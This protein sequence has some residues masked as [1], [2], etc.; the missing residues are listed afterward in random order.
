[1]K[2][3]S[4]FRF[5][6]KQELYSI[7]KWKVS[8]CTCGKV[9]QATTEW[10]HHNRQ[11][12]CMHIEEVKATFS[13]CPWVEVMFI[14]CAKWT[15]ILLAQSNNRKHEN[16]LIYQL[17]SPTECLTCTA[18]FHHKKEERRAATL[19]TEAEN[20]IRTEL[21]FTAMYANR[22]LFPKS[23][24]TG[25]YCAGVSFLGGVAFCWIFAQPKILSKP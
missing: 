18:F 7:L 4:V 23:P 8:V 25:K 3:C 15:S 5:H 22:L 6:N 14:H 19:T 2:P 21:L 9:P 24:T 16:V 10:S 20:S 1:M 12:S 11:H 13:P 17:Q